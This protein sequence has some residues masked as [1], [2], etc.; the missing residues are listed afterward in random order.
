MTDWNE[1]LQK[2]AEH[3]TEIELFEKTEAVVRK[4]GS[5]WCVFSKSGKNLGCFSTRK[6]ALKRLRQIEFFANRDNK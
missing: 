1:E 6:D 5:Q 4:Q 3:A 2:A